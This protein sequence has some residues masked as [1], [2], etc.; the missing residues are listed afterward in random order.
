[1][2][3]LVAFFTFV[4]TTG[5]FKRDAIKT[6]LGFVPKWDSTF[7]PNQYVRMVDEFESATYT[8]DDIVFLGNSITFHGNWTERLGSEKYKNRGISGDITF[9]LLNRLDS[10][11]IGK[12]KK[13]FIL[14]GVNDLK[15]NIPVYV[16]LNN[17]SRIVDSIRM[18]S[19]NTKIYF[20]SVLPVNP[21]I[22]HSKSLAKIQPQIPKLNEGL[23]LLTVQDHIAYIDLNSQFADSLGNLKRE[24]TIDG[25]HLMTKGY[26][27]W[28]RVLNDL[29]YLSE[30]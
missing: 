30:D 28:I 18:K 15:Y 6:R 5:F 22:N 10:S 16:I 11:C 1:M 25:L 7:R 3:I 9:G 8:P 21:S 12:P 4:I 13:I 29:G 27:Q 17:Y 20:Q 2:A 19:P 23:K 14:I 26:N 24:Y